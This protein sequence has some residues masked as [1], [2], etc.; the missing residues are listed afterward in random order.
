MALTL[1]DHESFFHAVMATIPS[2]IL[3]LDERLAVLTVNHN[4]L[5]KSRS[6]LS[7]ILGRRSARNLSRPPFRIRRSTGK[8][9]TS[10]SPAGRCTASA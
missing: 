10:S 4:F 5:E 3:I 8:S 6:S 1:L 9:A 7:S 2:S